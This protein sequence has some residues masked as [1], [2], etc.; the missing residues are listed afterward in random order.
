MKTLTDYIK[1]YDNVLSDSECFELINVFISGKQFHEKIHSPNSRP[2]FTQLN[3]SKHYSHTKGFPNLINT[4]K[5]CIDKYQI[6]TRIGDY[7]FP[8]T[9]AFEEIRI[10]RYKSEDE[11]RFDLHTDVADYKS[12]KRFLAFF[13]YLNEVEGGETSFPTLDLSISPKAGR[14]LIFPPLWM[15]P[16]SGMIPVSGTKYIISSY[17]HY[18]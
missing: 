14:I 7:Q 15:Y 13:V 5:K 4:F 11:E 3:Y 10:K 8:N 6:D 9:Y 16:H 12:S 1:V 18:L 2:R 17:L